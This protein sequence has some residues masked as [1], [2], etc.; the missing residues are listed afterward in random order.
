MILALLARIRV[1][2]QQVSSNC[3]IYYLR[4]AERILH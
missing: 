3:I 1:L 4:E 2:V